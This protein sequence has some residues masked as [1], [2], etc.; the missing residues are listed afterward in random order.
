MAAMLA[1]LRAA[2][3]RFAMKPIDPFGIAR[4]GIGEHLD[5]DVAV[6]LRVMRAIDL[7]HAT[8][9]DEGEDLVDAKADAGRKAHW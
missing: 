6:Q 7:A 5:C 4:V 2:I 9:A 8:R 3:L 1:W